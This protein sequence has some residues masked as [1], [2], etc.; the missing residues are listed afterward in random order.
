VHGVHD[1][2]GS[3]R[4]NGVLYKQ[5][6]C[7]THYSR[8]TSICDNKLTISEAKAIEMVI[9]GIRKVFTKPTIVEDLTLLYMQKHAYRR[10]EGRCG[11]CARATAR[12]G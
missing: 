8:G 6:G 11:R 12:G 2:V 9:G 10:E 1:G 4:A 7:T 3:K 5:Y